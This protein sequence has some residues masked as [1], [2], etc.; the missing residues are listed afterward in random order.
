MQ[1][2]LLM[3][4]LVLGL[5]PALAQQEDSYDE[6]QDSPNVHLDCGVFPAVRILVDGRETEGRGFIRYNRTYL[7]A[8]ETLERLGG[9]VT[10]VKAQRA[11][12]ARFPGKERTIRVTTGSRNVQ[13]YRYNAQSRYGAGQFIDT[14]RLDAAP[15]ICEGRVFAP[16][17]AAVEAA[18]GTVQYDRQTRTVYVTSPRS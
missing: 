4:V 6:Y 3:A 8:R 2:R 11:F 18:G 10:W 17:R 5:L 12:Y 7:P 13:I 16:V 9:T 14:I 1:A 15:F